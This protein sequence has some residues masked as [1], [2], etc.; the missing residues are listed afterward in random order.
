MSRAPFSLSLVPEV[1]NCQKFSYYSGHP[2]M[3]GEKLGCGVSPSSCPR[4]RKDLGSH[5]NCLL[6]N[7]VALLLEAET[8]CADGPFFPRNICHQRSLATQLGE[9]W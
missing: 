6:L 7:N 1:Q 8:Y 2:V 3:H 9:E 4:A 5:Q